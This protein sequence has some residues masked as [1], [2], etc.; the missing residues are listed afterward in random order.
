MQQAEVPSF[1]IPASSS[2]KPKD[3]RGLLRILEYAG[4]LVRVQEPIHWKFEIGRRTR[5][6]R[7]PLLFENV[8]DYPGQFL[9]T[10]GL[11]DPSAIALSLGLAPEIPWPDLIAEVRQRISCP[12][13]PLMVD[14]SPV[15]E[16]VF[17]REVVDLRRLPVPR[18]S[19]MDADRYLGTW[20]VN[21]TRDPESASRNVG[22]YRMQLLGAR[23]A[24]VSTSSESHLALQ[25]SRAE[26]KDLPLPM[27]VAIG[28]PE[29]VVMA[30][31]AACPQGRDEFEL[32]GALLGEPLPLVRCRTVQLEVPA[33]SEIVIEGFIHPG[34]RIQDG[35]FFDFLGLPN[36]N[37]NAYLFEAT[38]LLFRNSPI[39]RGA[40]VGLPGA[41][42]HQL[43]ALLASLG[44][45]D[46]H[47]NPWR[48]TIFNFLLKHRWFRTFQQAGR[49]GANF[50]QYRRKRISS[51][52]KVKCAR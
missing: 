43:F 29:P 25:V 7:S 1:A 52:A 28:V 49:L 17:L 34:V 13:A 30:A 31:S 50:R 10:N 16:N 19:E 8:E 15:F 5:E 42:D 23:T 44:L 45:L 6:S 51:L 40:S 3:L 48:Q 9:F 32:C 41:E 38:A 36:R 14:F 33:A 27:A 46:F 21:V 12:L 24:T 11:C 18:W 47:G 35:P 22:V 20:H 37:P 39:F 4:R 26:R 2:R